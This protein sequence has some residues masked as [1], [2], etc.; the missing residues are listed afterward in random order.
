PFSAVWRKLIPSKISGFIWQV[1]HKS[2]STF[3]NLAKRGF[4]G[5]SI[6]VLCRADLESVSHLFLGCRFSCSIWSTFSSKLAMF[7][8][9]DSDVSG[10]IIGWQGRNCVSEFEI[11]STGLMHAVFWYIW[12][13]RIAGFLERKFR[14]SQFWFGGL[15]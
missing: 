14:Q 2:I 7:G 10:F 12:E 1:F 4:V 11:F 3:D 6:C 8:P 9:T 15:P 5:P 13:K